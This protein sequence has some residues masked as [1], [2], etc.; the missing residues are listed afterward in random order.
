MP[1]LL[2]SRLLQHWRRFS[3]RIPRARAQRSFDLSPNR[4]LPT[5]VLLTKLRRA[6]VSIPALSSATAESNRR[7]GQSHS[8]AQARAVFVS[9]PCSVAAK[10]IVCQHNDIRM[11]EIKLIEDVEIEEM[12]KAEIGWL[13]GFKQIET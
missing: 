9:R 11:L 10:Q 2:R 1:D 6:R 5:R 4:P 7:A 12:P 13:I 3:R 8:R